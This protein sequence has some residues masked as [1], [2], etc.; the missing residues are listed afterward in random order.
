MLGEAHASGLQGAHSYSLSSRPETAPK[1]LRH[2]P[3]HAP[4][5]PNPLPAPREVLALLPAPSSLL[6]LLARPFC[7]QIARIARKSCPLMVPTKATTEMARAGRV[8]APEIA[9]RHDSRPLEN[10]SFGNTEEGVTWAG[11]IMRDTCSCTITTRARN[12]R[13]RSTALC[14]VSTN[15]CDFAFAKMY[16]ISLRF[17]FTLFKKTID[18]AFFNAG[19]PCRSVKF[20]TTVHS[21]GNRSSTNKRSDA[22][23]EN[24]PSRYRRAKTTG[25]TEA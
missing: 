20:V 8:I 6:S 18:A 1:T 23:F 4:P 24:F 2:P 9:I 12:L 14:F 7:G 10:A 16:Y 15:L 19:N 3:V 17:A 25:W 21:V 22:E 13:F 11:E 5:R